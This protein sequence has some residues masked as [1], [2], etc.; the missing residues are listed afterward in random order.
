MSNGHRSM[1][2]ALTDCDVIKDG[3]RQLDEEWQYQ[4]ESS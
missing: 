2:H 3:R 1:I 4:L